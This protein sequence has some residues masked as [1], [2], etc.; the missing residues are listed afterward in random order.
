MN[1]SHLTYFKKLAEV[2]HFTKAASELYVSQPTLSAAISSLEKELNTRLFYRANNKIELTPCGEEFCDYVS[3]G[4]RIIEQGIQAVEEY[5]GKI[6]GTL[7]LGTL[8]AIQSKDWSQAI[9]SFQ[10]ECGAGLTIN[11]TQGF[12]PSLFEGL[13]SGKLDVIFAG[14]PQTSNKYN[15]TYCWAQEL[16]VAVNKKHPL[17]KKSV[18]SLAD[19]AKFHII[20]Y[21]EESPVYDEMK[22]LLQQAEYELDVEY[23]YNDEITLSSLVNSDTNDVALLC[24][25]FLVKAFDDVVYLPLQDAPREF[26]KVYLISNKAITQPRVV[27]D[28]VTYMKNYHFPTAT[29]RPLQK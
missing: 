26:H 29:V 2:K 20:S 13:A 25:S 16:A 4:L 11:I 12:T 15:C 22:A 1:F 27:S 24:Y 17:A 19:L 23:A 8:Y 10:D 14:K 9:Q 3:R 6:N 7:N 18:V 5:E 28:F 21:H